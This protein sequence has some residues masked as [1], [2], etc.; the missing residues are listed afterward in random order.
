[1]AYE[2][3]G[4]E[5]STPKESEKSEFDIKKKLVRHLKNKI[6]PSLSDSINIFK[7]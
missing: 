1:M 5:S 4:S 3:S 6:D 2:G 7:R